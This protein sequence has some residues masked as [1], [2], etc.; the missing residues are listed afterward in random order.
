[1]PACIYAYHVCAQW[2]MKLEGVLNPLERE[3][4]ICLQVGAG[5]GTWVPCKSD[6]GSYHW[7]ISTDLEAS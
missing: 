3:L 5:N 7:A 2:S 4:Q 1:M 6:K